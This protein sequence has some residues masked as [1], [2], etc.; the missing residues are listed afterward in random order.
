LV[1]SKICMSWTVGQFQQVST[2]RDPVVSARIQHGFSG[3][4]SGGW[5]R[6]ASSNTARARSQEAGMRWP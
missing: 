2:L 6:R 5:R 1:P 4:L 3:V